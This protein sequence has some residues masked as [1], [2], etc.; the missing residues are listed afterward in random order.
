MA[1]AK[2][3]AYEAITDRI[4]T[5]LESGTVPWRRPW[6]SRDRGTLRNG[7][8]GHEYRGINTVVLTLETLS[9]GYTDPRWVTFK[10]ALDAGGHVRKGESGTP[11]VFWSVLRKSETGADGSEESRAFPLLK[12]YTVFNVEQCDGL[13]LSDKHAPI[14][15][16]EGSAWSPDE[17][18]EG[19]VRGFRDAPTIEHD[20]GSRAF[21][22][23]TSD[24]IHLP[25]RESF[26]E[27]SGYYG[28]LFHELS[29]ST[30]HESRLNRH[31]METGIAAFGSETYSREELAAEF[32]SAFLCGEAGFSEV[33][34]EQNAAYVASWL[35]VLKG[36]KRLAIVAASQ[37][38][39]AADY[40]LGR[41]NGGDA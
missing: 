29:H 21:Y 10:Q 16:G 11:L 3:P 34:V 20:G 38:Q 24:A 6:V 9:T 26:T 28:T 37:G 33:Q 30:G 12:R 8:S 32:G 23:P 2:A 39:K 40:V 17:T 18:A 13:T 1:S 25:A 4:I 22:R 27:A 5:A 31:G 41:S 14:E 36:D 35:R 19:I 15:A 7:A